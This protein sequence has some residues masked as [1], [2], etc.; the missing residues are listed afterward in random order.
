LNESPLQKMSKLHPQKK[1]HIT[2]F[3]TVNLPQ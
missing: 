2:S 3:Y 1:T